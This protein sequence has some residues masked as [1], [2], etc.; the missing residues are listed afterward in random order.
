MKACRL[1]A[2][3][4]VALASIAAHTQTK[5]SPAVQAGYGRLPLSFEANQG[6]T[7]PQVK[8]TSRGQG[9]ALFLTDSAAVLSLSK[10][11]PG[12]KPGAPFKPGVGLSGTAMRTPQVPDLRPGSGTQSPGLNQTKTDVVRMELVGAA[13]NSQAAG[14]EQLPGKANYF[15]GNDPAKWHSNV[16]TYAKVRYSAVYP[17]VD[18]VYYGSQRQLEYDFIL[19]PGAD[20]K[21]IQLRFAGAEKLKLNADGDLAVTAKNGEIAF[22][23]PVVYQ[24]ESGVASQPANG[25]VEGRDPVQGKFVLLANNTVG[26]QLGNYDHSREL[27][28]DPHL[29]YSTYLGGSGLDRSRCI[30]VD[31]AGNAYVAGSTSSSDFPVTSGVFQT[32]TKSDFTGFVTKINPAGSALVYSTYLGGNNVDFLAAIAVDGSGNAYVGG[33]TQ[34]PDFPVTPGAFQTNF[35]ETRIPF[36]SKLNPTGSALIYSTFLGGSDSDYIGGLAINATGEVYVT[37]G[38]YSTDFPIT[39]G[40]FLGIK[41]ADSEVCFVTRFNAEGSALVYSTF[42][43]SKINSTCTGIAVDGFNKAYVTGSSPSQNFPVTPGAFQT[44]PPGWINAFVT[45]LNPAGSRLEYSTYLGGKGVSMATGIALDPARNAYVFGFTG[46]TDFPVTKGAYDT[47]ISDPLPA[48]NFVTKLDPTGSFLVYSTFFR[49]PNIDSTISSIAVDGAGHAFLAGFTLSS[50]FPVISGAAQRLYRGN[51]DAFLT[52]LSVDGSALGYSTYFG[53]TGDD[54][55][56][57]VAVDSA[58]SAYLLGNT[59][60]DNLI[61]TPGVYQPRYNGQ[62]GECC[63]VGNAFIA[64]FAFSNATLTSTQVSTSSSS[65]PS[66]TAVTFTATVAPVSGTWTPT[67]D[68]SFRIDGAPYIH[69][70]LDSSGHAS[71]STDTLTAGQ[72]TITAAYLGTPHYHLAP[73]GYA[74]SSASLL[75]TITAE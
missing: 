43:T 19:A 69:V 50:T 44:V 74:P 28:I 64:K 42:L 8:F 9:Y 57:A 7:D 54:Y 14:A 37:G 25:S 6:Q 73:D 29:A 16:P 51:D 72:H 27:V 4:L 10:P 2:A 48:D 5:P 32:T 24:R 12:T 63:L 58:G 53:G 46:S 38:S 68:V 23:K 75:Q 45:K 30:A 17:G 62:F 40:A 56:A 31:N 11:E 39:P 1:A 67:G 20:P 65:E 47:T 15:L 52:E 59:D 3:S 22:H 18:L 49:N 71:Y 21:P 13:P 26:F 36:L 35:S 55:A 33:Y 41:A 34:S 66:G 61:V 60:S 70:T